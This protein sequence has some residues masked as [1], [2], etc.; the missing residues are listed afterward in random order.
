MLVLQSRKY[1][2]EAGVFRTASR[3][4]C[5]LSA[6]WIFGGKDEESLMCTKICSYV[7]SVQAQSGLN[8]IRTIRVWVPSLGIRVFVHLLSFSIGTKRACEEGR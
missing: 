8:V 2:K 5:I 1:R 4:F 7:E 3:D 6:V